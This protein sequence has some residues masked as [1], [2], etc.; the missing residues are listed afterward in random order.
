MI[1]AVLIGF[2]REAHAYT[3]PGSGMLIWQFV[4]AGVVGI[5]FYVRRIFDWFRSK[6]RRD[7]QN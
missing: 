7:Q 2:E 1:V 3:D 6:L 5:M 4:I